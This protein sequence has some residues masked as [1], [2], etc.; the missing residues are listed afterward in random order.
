HTSPILRGYSS[1]GWI[2][3]EEG[4]RSAT[5]L[6]WLTNDE[7]T[8]ILRSDARYESLTDRLKAVAKKT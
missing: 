2:M 7:E 8:D 1:G 4:N 5:M 3:E 6:E